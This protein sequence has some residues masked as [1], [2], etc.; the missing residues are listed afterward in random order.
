[1]RPLTRLSV[2]AL[3][4]AAFL[5]L[6]CDGVAP[7]AAGDAPT[8]ASLTEAAPSR[9]TVC[10]Y[11]APA[12][13]WEALSLP[14]AAAAAH[15][16]HALDG[17]P[18]EAVPGRSGYTFDAACQPEAVPPPPLP[19]G[20]CNVQWPYALTA[21][22]GVPSSEVYGQLWIEGDAGT[23]QPGA[24]PG[25]LAS[26]G[27]GLAGSDASSAAWSWSPMAFNTDAGNNDEFVATITPTA[28]GTFHYLTRFSTDG[29]TSWT[30]CGLG[31]PTTPAGYAA[32]GVL[33]VPW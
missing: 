9:Q 28:V 11:D 32:P 3:V 14:A 8:G 17:A 31:G 25:V 1:M 29:G 18:G 33:T 27:V 15:A 6:G 26:L 21:Y 16:R 20:W 22:V 24:T 7:D 12:D 10:H 5:P 23:R 19:I 4:A 2:A 30:Y 13:A